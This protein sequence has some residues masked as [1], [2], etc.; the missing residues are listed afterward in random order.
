MLLNTGAPLRTGRGIPL[1]SMNRV[2]PLL[3]AP[4]L[5]P[6]ST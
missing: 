6:V 1:M 3:G 4:A 5:S 2:N